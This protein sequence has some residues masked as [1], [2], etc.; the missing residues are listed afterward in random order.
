[1]KQQSKTVV[2]TAAVTGLMM[3]GC[4]SA[5]KPVADVVMGECHGINACKGQGECGGVGHACAGKNSC[6]GKGWLKMSHADCDDS[7]GKYKAESTN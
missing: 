3:V 2:I 5:P 7:A 4:A 1:M 6:K